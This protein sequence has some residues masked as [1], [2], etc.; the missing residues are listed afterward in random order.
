[1]SPPGA[2]GFVPAGGLIRLRAL[3]PRMRTG[4]GPTG[5]CEYCGSPEAKPAFDHALGREVEACPT[6]VAVSMEREYLDDGTGVTG[7]L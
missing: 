1:V 3:F 5:G 4:R 2:S 6:C 7:G